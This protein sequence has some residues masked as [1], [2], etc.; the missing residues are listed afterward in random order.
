M[1]TKPFFLTY[2]NRGSDVRKIDGL[3][4]HGLLRP[5]AKRTR[6]KRRRGGGGQHGLVDTDHTSKVDKL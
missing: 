5:T 6:L 4:G 3:S 2:V 1:S